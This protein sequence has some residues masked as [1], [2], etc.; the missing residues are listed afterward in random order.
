MTCYKQEVFLNNDGDSDITIG[1]MI[2]PSKGS[3]QIWDNLTLIDDVL[4]NFTECK[5]NIAK[6]NEYIGTGQLTLS[7]G[8]EKTV[9]EAFNI[10]DKMLCT[11][12]CSLMVLEQLQIQDFRWS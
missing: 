2:I 1:D 7:D 12:N 6:F 9:Q 8:T 11:Y 5:D 4:Y 10:F 3:V